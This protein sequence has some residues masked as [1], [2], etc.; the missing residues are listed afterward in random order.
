M[1]TN[2]QNQ[3]RCAMA[4]PRP[5]CQDPTIFRHMRPKDVEAFALTALVYKV[6]IL[7]RRTNPD[8]LQY[9]GMPGFIPKHIDCKAKTADNN[10][11]LNGRLQEIA[12]LVVDP[13]IAGPAA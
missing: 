4:P 8:S 10:V 1:H 9:I 7:V 11:L 12:G 2:G 5:I 3:F 13:N 6:F